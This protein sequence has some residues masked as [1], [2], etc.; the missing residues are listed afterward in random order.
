MVTRW[1]LNIQVFPCSRLEEHEAK[2]FPE[3]LKFGSR[4]SELCHMTNLAARKAEEA[5]AFTWTHETMNNQDSFTK[6]KGMHFGWTITIP[7]TEESNFSSHLR[8]NETQTT[9]KT[10]L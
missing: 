2:A 7:A 9:G 4:W 8:H 6:E 1:L 5:S 3:T 10:D